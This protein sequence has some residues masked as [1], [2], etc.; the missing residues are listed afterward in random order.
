[1]GWSQVTFPTGILIASHEE[2]Q[3]LDGF[4]TGFPIEI[5]GQFYKNFVVI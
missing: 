5:H 4:A 1:M 3:S 2:I